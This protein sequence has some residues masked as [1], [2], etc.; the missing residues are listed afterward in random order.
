MTS[1]S[2]TRKGLNIQRAIIP[3][4]ILS[5]VLVMEMGCESKYPGSKL[6]LFPGN[7]GDPDAIL[8]VFTKL[9]TKS[10]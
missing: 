8:N 10:Y 3:G 2:V 6:I 1:A 5:G 7:V 9:N 4:Q